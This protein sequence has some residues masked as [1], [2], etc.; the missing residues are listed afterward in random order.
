MVSG[1][2]EV[3]ADALM[4]GVREQ[5][6]LYS[7]VTQADELLAMQI[8]QEQHD[9]PHK[10]RISTYVIWFTLDNRP[11]RRER[12]N[13]QI[14]VV[15]Q[16]QVS[17]RGSPIESSTNVLVSVCH[18]LSQRRMLT[19]AVLAIICSHLLPTSQFFYLAKR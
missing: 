19:H 1:E 17:L 8:K 14:A 10:E 13:A 4:V 11:A 6:P 9:H 3:G 7:S 2:E 18:V 15:E 16:S 12:Q 5:S